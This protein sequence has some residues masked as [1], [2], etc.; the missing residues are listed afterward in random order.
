LLYG[1]SGK[2]LVK[3]QNQESAFIIFKTKKIKYADMGFIYKGDS[4]IKV[5]IYGM[6]QPLFTLNINGMNICMSTFE[7]MEKNE[8]NKKMLSSFYPD[9][10]LENIFRGAIIFKGKNLEK[11]SNGFTQ[12]IKKPEKYDIVYIVNKESR[13][14]KDKINNIK[15]EVNIKS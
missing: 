3:E 7:C 4:F 8:F 1:C 6:G 2:N 5:E 9:T 11:R 12:K 13:I 15:I 10:L 14:F